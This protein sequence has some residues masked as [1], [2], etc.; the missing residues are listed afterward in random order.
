MRRENRCIGSGILDS[1]LKAVYVKEFILN[2][3]I[4]TLLA[5]GA[6][7]AGSALHAWFNH[8]KPLGTIRAPRPHGDFVKSHLR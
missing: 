8:G 3:G 7:Y 5:L 4:P 6:G 1:N 2:R